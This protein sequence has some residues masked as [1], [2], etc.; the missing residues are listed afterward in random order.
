MVGPGIALDASFWTGAEDRMTRRQQPAERVDVRLRA[1]GVAALLLLGVGCASFGP[2]PEE[3]AREAIQALQPELAQWQADGE[4]GAA[5]ESI[6]ALVTRYPS[7]HEVWALRAE[8]R[9]RAGDTADALADWRK[10]VEQAAAADN[11]QAALAHA[12]S[13]A[14]LVEVEPDWVAE[15]AEAAASI[16]DDSE[17][18]D[19]AAF[20]QGLMDEA[21]ELRDAGDLAAAED[22]LEQALSVAESYFGSEHRLAVLSLQE[23]ADTALA[24]DD[25]DGALALLEVALE[26]S[27]LQPGPA[28]PWTQ[29][30]AESLVA[31]LV[32]QG[33]QQAALE[34]QR[35]LH[36][37]V[38]E[39]YHPAAP[40][41]QQQAWALAQRLEATGAFAKASELLATSC[42]RVTERYG[43][44]HPRTAD[45]HEQR[46]IALG[47][48]GRLSAATAAFED[49][50]AIRETLFAADARPLLQTRLDLVA[51][52]RRQGE[53]EQAAASVSELS[54]A[55]SR[56]LPDDDPL[57]E[58]VLEEQAR[59]ALARGELEAAARHAEAVLALR[60]D[61]LA[62]DHPLRLDAMNL[63]GAVYRQAGKLVAAEEVWTAA[64]AGY[65]AR[66]GDDHLATIT[67]E[68]N[69]GV[70]LEAQGRFDDAE[71]LLRGAV[72]RSE[73]LLGPGHP[74][75]LASMNNLALLYERQ[76]RFKRAE[77]LYL[78]P[79]DVLES[80]LGAQHPDSIAV[81][82]NLAFLYMKEGRHEEAAAL[83]EELYQAWQEALGPEHPDTLRGLNNLGRAE[84]ERGRL[85]EARANLQAAL[86]GRRELFG[87]EHPDS[88]RSLLDLGLLARDADDLSRA[89]RLL[90]AAV[91]DSEAVLGD[92]HPYT[93]E[94]LNALADVEEQQERIDTAFE[95]RRQVFERRNRFYDRMLWVTGD[96]AREGYLRLHRDEF[97][98]YLSLLP[99]LDQDRAAPALL[100]AAF[101]RKGLLL[102]VTSEIR[103]VAQMELDPQLSELADRLS[104]QREALASLT[105]AGPGND[106]PS[107]HLAR[108]RELEAEI[109]ELQGALGRSSLRYRE[110]VAERE[111]QDVVQA[112]DAGEA[113]VDFLVH[114]REDGRQGLLAGILYKS[115]DGEVSQTLVHY[116]DMQPLTD[117]IHEY[118]EIIQDPSALDEDVEYVGQL[119]WEAVWEPLADHL[120]G[121]RNIHVVP[122]GVLNLLPFH[123][124]VDPSG[125]FMLETHQLSVLSSSRDLIP[126]RLPNGDERILV[127]GGPDYDTEAVA[128]EDTLRQ[129]RERR[130][131]RRR[132]LRG[133]DEA[134][135][136]SDMPEASRGVATAQL[137]PNAAADLQ[138][139]RAAARGLRGL[140]FSPLPGARIEGQRIGQRSEEAQR[141][142]KLYTGDGAEEAVLFGLNRAPAVLHLATHGFFLQPDAELRQRLTSAQRSLDVQTP[143]PG[144]NPLLRSGLAFAGANS[145]APFLGELD[146][147]NDGVLTALEVLSLNLEGT[148]IAVLSA[149]ETGL[150]EIYPGEGLYGLRRA[151][152]EAGV[153]QVVTSLWAVS[154]AGTQALMDAF[155]QHLFEG[156][157]PA[158]ALRLAQRE[159]M[160]SPRWGYPFIWGAFVLVGV[161]APAS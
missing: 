103:Q 148:R 119:A 72:D 135:P 90:R 40:A 43:T 121:T 2:P 161:E 84:R 89:R 133:E 85:D 112:L 124:L 94:A 83:F 28:H 79:L 88:I 1:F 143:P 54:T 139:L 118:R 58:A 56:S 97:D 64:L 115:A 32:D 120:E 75:T 125:Q 136:A 74:Q 6:D 122:D 134:A 48:A 82:N 150:G 70:L 158:K 63:L 106:D 160:T 92:A 42:S 20:W 3:A 67:A 77:P 80:T 101:A 22:V 95:L 151:F 78:L 12:R 51:M 26:R 19:A 98:R 14:A 9:Q 141:S 35:E 99:Q 132:V 34:L 130:S 68:S 66:Y 4:T 104:E 86:D 7:V 23:L 110:S 96:N 137:D 142:N 65:R 128:G 37:D 123:A 156:E 87:R 111:F 73:S 113:L 10:A 131:A 24:R 15:Q 39:H 93:F 147:R 11:Q 114:G 69:L 152:Q 76:G 117:V 8:W 159:L 144:D 91:N 30:V 5:L 53:L 44:L 126:T 149:C 17:L 138:S 13:L 140:S 129:A 55:V 109:N 107:E 38:S 71:P 31:V 127:M 41:T 50:L 46:A 47:R 25:T 146:T 45:C 59:T 105:L 33:A 153:R 108:I 62:E 61:R 16:G 29:E 102:K 155:Y 49:V 154:D 60:G 145:N 100:E 52:A 57:H 27:R 157:A 18:A 36:E 116:P 81:G 21:A